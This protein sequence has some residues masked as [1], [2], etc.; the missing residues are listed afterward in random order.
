MVCT[1][2]CTSAKAKTRVS[3]SEGGSELARFLVNDEAAKSDFWYK[4][5][6][7]PWLHVDAVL[8]ISFAIV[9][10]CLEIP[11]HP[12]TPPLPYRPMNFLPCMMCI[13]RFAL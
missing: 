9:S 8:V 12:D 6:I 10:Y 1:T 3:R 2:L 7:L 4:A 13:V 11:S 5:R